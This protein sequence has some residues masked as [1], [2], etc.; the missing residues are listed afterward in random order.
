MKPLLHR[1]HLKP[2]KNILAKKEKKISLL[3]IEIM[4]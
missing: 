4:L 3:I 2:Y 1:G